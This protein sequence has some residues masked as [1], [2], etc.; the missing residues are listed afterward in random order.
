VEIVAG[1]VL[2]D[3]P[4]NYR[5]RLI[6][7]TNVDATG[8]YAFRVGPGEYQLDL[9][10]FLPKTERLTVTNQREIVVDSEFPKLPPPLRGIVVDRAGKPVPLAFVRYM[11]DGSHIPTL[12]AKTAALRSSDTSDRQGMSMPATLTPVSLA[13]R[14]LPRTKTMSPS[15]PTRQPQSLAGWSMRPAGRSPDE[16]GVPLLPSANAPACDPGLGRDRQRGQ[17]QVE[18]A[19]TRLA[20]GNVLPPVQCEASL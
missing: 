2:G 3:E 8:H 12:A 9:P 19:G 20:W 13:S 16:C 6:R 14:P 15:L 7:S 17:V 4:D 1:L 18:H 5:V 10:G 11:G